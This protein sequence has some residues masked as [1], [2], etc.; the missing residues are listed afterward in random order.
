MTDC[1]ANT[2]LSSNTQQVTKHHKKP[3]YIFRSGSLQDQNKGKAFSVKKGKEKTSLKP[4]AN[5]YSNY[6]SNISAGNQT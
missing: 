2:F 3:V 6:L 4:V 5:V 1:I